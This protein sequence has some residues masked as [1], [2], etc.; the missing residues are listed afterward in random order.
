MAY[1]KMLTELRR[2]SSNATTKDQGDKLEQLVSL[3]WQAC[4]NVFTLIGSRSTQVGQ[5][6]GIVEIESTDLIT[7]G[8]GQHIVYECKNWNSRPGL[9]EVA[10]LLFKMLLV[11]AYVGIMFSPE[12]ITE[13]KGPYL[14]AKGVITFAYWRLKRVILHFD[15]RDL[16][17]IHDGENFIEMLNE[18]Y[19]DVKLSLPSS[20]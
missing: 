3:L 1:S 14:N 16:K 2:E 5:I 11:D 13:P 18:K 7:R 4:E 19:R 8:W 12:G 10:V 20:E 15:Q 9:P 6:D 17:R